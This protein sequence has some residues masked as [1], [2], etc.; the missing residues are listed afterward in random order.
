MSD[1]PV[2]VAGASG[3][4]G[5][6]L[7][8][9]FRETVPETVGTA[10]SQTCAGLERLDLRDAD[11]VRELVRSVAPSAV[12]CAAAIPSVEQCELEPKA[13]SAV[14]VAGTLALA[15]AAREAG[16]TF[17][18]LSSEYVFDG[19]DGPYS[20]DDPTNPIN[21]YGRQKVA[22]E[23]ALSA[24]DDGDF[25]IARV[26]CVYGHEAQRKNFVYQV[27]SALTAGRALRMPSDQVGSPTAAAN[28]ADVIRELWQAGARGIFHVVG[29]DRMIRSDFAAIA[30]EELGLDPTLVSPT[31][32]E[33][34]G[35]AAPRP[36]GAGLL[37]DRA[38]AAATTSLVG[39]REGIRR[40]LEQ[41]PLEAAA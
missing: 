3:L 23:K 18:F 5:S 25:I 9:T 6:H 8:A 28:A 7:L 14:N 22:V 2:L 17:V 19:R 4:A 31:P 27:W 16:A 24:R 40:M 30:A 34:L 10:L 38:A 1:R 35:L 13:T 15:E 36:L 33:E 11:A 20:E 41:A 21:E 39:I 32:T 29:P 26:S 37:N 12:V